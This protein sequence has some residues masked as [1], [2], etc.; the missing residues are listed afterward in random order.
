MKTITLII[1]CIALLGCETTPT[2]EDQAAARAYEAAAIQEANS[3]TCEQ[4]Q[5]T[6]GT[7]EFSNCMMQLHINQDQQQAQVDLVYRQQILQ[8]LQNR[9]PFAIPPVEFHPLPNRY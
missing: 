4:F 2:A 7:P 8:M 6:P 3:S 9:Q 5:F 1:A